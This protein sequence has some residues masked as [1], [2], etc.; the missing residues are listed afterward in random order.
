MEEAHL[1][2]RKSFSGR[3]AGVAART[4][5]DLDFNRVQDIS[6]IDLRVHH[7]HTYPCLVSLSLLCYDSNQESSFTL[8]L[9]VNMSPYLQYTIHFW[10]LKHPFRTPEC[11]A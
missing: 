2:R 10:Q 5:T 8:Q 3:V 11:M 7:H 6:I 1:G 9:M 4:A